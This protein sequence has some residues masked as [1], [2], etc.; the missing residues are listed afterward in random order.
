MVKLLDE[1]RKISTDPGS[2][3]VT[4][5]RSTQPFTHPVVLMKMRT[6]RA[7]FWAAI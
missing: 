7:P 2:I 5:Q 3:P 6:W 1:E 4:L